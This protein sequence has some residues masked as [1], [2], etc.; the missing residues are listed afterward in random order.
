MTHFRLITIALTLSGLSACYA[1]VDLLGDTGPGSSSQIDAGIVDMGNPLDSG[2][3]PVRSNCPETV[4]E[5]TLCLSGKVNYVDDRLELSL[6]LLL[7]PGCTN[8]TQTYAEITYDNML[9]APILMTEFPG[10]GYPPGCILHGV[11]ASGRFTWHQLTQSA[12]SG[13]VC[14]DYLEPGVLE[15]IT[16]I[17]PLDELEKTGVS[18]GIENV[19]IGDNFADPA[20]RGNKGISYS[21][22]PQRM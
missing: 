3:A 9:V 6:N 22:P 4:T 10:P 15:T 14:P 19:S 13:S 20:C 11:Q 7:P 17:A 12:S 18:I 2:T 1:D 8:T 21:I 5:A 16:L